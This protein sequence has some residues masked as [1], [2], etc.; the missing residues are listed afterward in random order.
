MTDLIYCE[1]CDSNVVVL[2]AEDKGESLIA[3]AGENAVR[4]YSDTS[5]DKLPVRCKN[6]S[7][8]CPRA[9]CVIAELQPALRP[10]NNV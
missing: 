5:F 9:R 3:G 6:L 8:G 1:A 10:S 4:F 2:P 7:L